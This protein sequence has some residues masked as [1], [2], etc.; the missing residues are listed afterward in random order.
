MLKQYKTLTI[1]FL[2][3]LL[4]L[5]QSFG[6]GLSYKWQAGKTYQFHAQEEVNMSLQSSMIEMAS[7]NET[8]DVQTSFAFEV[9]NVLSN[10]TAEGIL[11]ILQFEVADKK[12]GNILAS[13][14]D[15]PISSLSNQATVTNKGV[16]T[17]KKSTYL[18]IDEAAHTSMLVSSSIDVEDNSAS[19]SGSANVNGQ[20]VNLHASFDTKTGSLKS[21]Y[22][23]KTI[24]NPTKQKIKVSEEAINLDILPITYL[25][26][27]Q[28]PEE[29]IQEGSKIQSK[30]MDYSF[31]F[32]AK[33]VTND[34]VELEV[35]VS[36]EQSKKQKKDSNNVMDF[37]SF[38]KTL[39][40]IDSNVEAIV[41]E[42]FTGGDPTKVLGKSTGFGALMEI[43]MNCLLSFDKTVGM[44]NHLEGQCTS[45]TNM[46]G[47]KMT[48]V[49]NVKILPV[50]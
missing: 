25:E 11:H 43:N 35:V 15:I 10:G 13:I 14:K 28:L 44:I 49:S 50:E 12:T 36:T 38:E 17:L 42:V 3:L 21:E 41:D 34:N 1:L 40:D 46:A 5:H 7:V 20:E 24:A 27:L 33:A 2:I 30:I 9:E 29:S 23:L 16:F 4:N 22:S 31:I 45:S 37:D 39:D 26:L 48:I 6:T 47:M 18:I 32:E 19:V 8:Y